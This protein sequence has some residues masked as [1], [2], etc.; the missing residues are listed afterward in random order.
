VNV[1]LGRL[2]GDTTAVW[3]LVV[4]ATH[5]P[6]GWSIDFGLSMILPCAAD[7][8]AVISVEIPELPVTVRFCTS[9]S[10]HGVSPVNRN[11]RGPGLR[12]DWYVNSAAMT[13]T[14]RNPSDLGYI[15]D[16]WEKDDGT[17]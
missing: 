7:G 1:G 11:Q 2:G 8:F 12:S 10:S 9:T 5:S 13:M 6:V 14:K 3:P 15:E 16:R 4:R 17:P